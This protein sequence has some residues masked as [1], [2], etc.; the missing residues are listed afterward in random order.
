VK[1]EG[2]AEDVT[3]SGGENISSIEIE[4]MLCP[5]PRR[6]D[7]RRG[8]QP[9]SKWGETPLAYVELKPGAQATEMDRPG[10]PGRWLGHALLSM[11]ITSVE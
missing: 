10:P 11:W 2:R 8:H 7:G 3:I 6:G 1:I 9:D 4:G 5:S